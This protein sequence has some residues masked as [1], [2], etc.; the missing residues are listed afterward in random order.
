MRCLLLLAILFL[1]GC[2]SQESP[3]TYLTGEWAPTW[4]Q[5]D[6]WDAPPFKN[7]SPRVGEKEY[8]FRSRMGLKWKWRNGNQLYIKTGPENKHV[9][10]AELGTEILLD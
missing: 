10:G 8:I 4:E 5:D 3:R 7:Y 1:A 2:A 9:W 6:L